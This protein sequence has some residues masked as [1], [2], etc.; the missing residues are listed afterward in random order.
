LVNSSSQSLYQLRETHF[1]KL[2]HLRVIVYVAD[3]CVGA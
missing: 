3:A 2:T 1:T